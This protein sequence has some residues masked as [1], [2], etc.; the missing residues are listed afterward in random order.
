MQRVLTRE[1]L[2]SALTETRNIIASAVESSSYGGDKKKHGQDAKNA[3][4]RSSG[5]IQ[6]VHS[7]IEE[8]IYSKLTEI[9]IQARAWPP[10]GA[11]S[12]E[13]KVTGLLKAKDQ[14][15]SF[16]VDAHTE[17]LITTGVEAGRIDPVGYHATN[18]ALVVGVRSQLSSVAKNFD[19][20]VER[21]FAETLNLR[22]RT[23]NITL[24][25]VY[26]IPL[27]EFDDES[28]KQNKIGFKTA[29]INL[30]K[31]TKIFNAITDPNYRDDVRDL[32]KYNATMLI[33]ADFALPKV[34]ILWDEADVLTKFDNH[35][36]ESMKELLPCNFVDNITRSYVDAL[37]L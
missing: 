18:R 15:I 37:R 30:S 25:E 23:P 26:L 31:F 17:E 21:A 28:L 13:L 14:D 1:S 32:Y 10:I 7:I 2:E 8:A 6:Q 20:L 12:P 29:P 33:V 4:I 19:T 3:A 11:K 24:G 16:T 35:M 36:A 22:L 5:P 27:N 34:K 9:G